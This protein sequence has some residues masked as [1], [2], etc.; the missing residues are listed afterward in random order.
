MKGKSGKKE[1]AK[2]PTAVP[3][4]AP[5]SSPPVAPQELEEIGDTPPADEPEDNGQDTEEIVDP[6]TEEQEAVL[7]SPVV[8]VIAY[9][10]SCATCG[11]PVNPNW[12]ECPACG[13][14]HYVKSQDSPFLGIPAALAKRPKK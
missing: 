8:R 10:K 5:P 14:T 2:E 7:K 11:I 6:E 9:G 3:P 12:K 4:I 13:D 1:I